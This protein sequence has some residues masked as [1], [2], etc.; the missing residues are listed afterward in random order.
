MIRN[1][2]RLMHAEID[3]LHGGRLHPPPPTP[4]THC[5][6]IKLLYWE[7]EDSNRQ[8]VFKTFNVFRFLKKVFKHFLKL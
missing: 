5:N 3:E 2:I 6:A 4:P 8:Q 7:H 1:L